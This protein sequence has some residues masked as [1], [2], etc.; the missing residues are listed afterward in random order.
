[1]SIMSEVRMNSRPK[2]LSQQPRVGTFFITCNY[3]E[4]ALTDKHQAILEDLQTLAEAIQPF[5]VEEGRENEP[6]AIVELATAWE[7]VGT[8]T[9]NPHWHGIVKLT[10]QK[11]MRLP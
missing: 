4:M 9:G 10:R 3:A 6:E 1:M 7:E 11:R 5:M 2:P 8:T